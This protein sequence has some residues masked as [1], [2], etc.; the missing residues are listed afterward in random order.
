MAKEKWT[1]KLVAKRFE[2]AAETMRRLP[3]VRVQGYVSS[4][5]PVLREYFESYGYDR[6]TIRLGP[7]PGEAIDQMDECLEW[8]R[9]LEPKEMRLVWLRAEHMPWKL[10]LRHLGVSRATA[11]QRLMSARLKVATFLNAHV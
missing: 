9:W 1:P 4:W 6:P 5:P 8:L 10:I 11:W 2:Y 3:A 7:P